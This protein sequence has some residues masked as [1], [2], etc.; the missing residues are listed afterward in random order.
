VARDS[1]E[2]PELENPIGILV[3]FVLG[4]VVDPWI[5]ACPV[6]VVEIV[7]LGTK[8]RGNEEEITAAAPVVIE[9]V[10]RLDPSLRSHAENVRRSA[11]SAS[12]GVRHIALCLS[13]I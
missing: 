2:I 6:V 7:D 4:R 8:K 3:L 9:Y 5:R 12:R 11:A 13:G 10:F 1:S